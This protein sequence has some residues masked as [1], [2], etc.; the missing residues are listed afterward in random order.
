MTCL[1][2]Y[3]LGCMTCAKAAGSEIKP[4][5]SN[6]VPVCSG[7]CMGAY[8]RWC[9]IP[10]CPLIL[11]TLTSPT[12]LAHLVNRFLLQSLRATKLKAG[13]PVVLSKPVYCAMVV[14]LQMVSGGDPFAHRGLICIVAASADEWTSR[15]GMV[16]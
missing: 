14:V 10:Q 13:A 16:T 7:T 12:W 9:P 1:G 3:S 8:P 11:P 15:R 6:L 2:L 4:C 5:T